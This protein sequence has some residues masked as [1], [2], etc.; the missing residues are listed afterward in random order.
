MSGVRRIS[1]GAAAFGRGARLG[2]RLDGSGGALVRSLPAAK[3]G[4]Q[5]GCAAGDERSEYRA[6]CADQGDVAGAA[7]ADVMAGECAER[8]TEKHGADN[9]D[10][11]TL[12][13]HGHILAPPASRSHPTLPKVSW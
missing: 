6:A 5:P 13:V 7:I 3:A 11:Q 10:G 2:R 12:R 1:E 9:P 8:R 4:Q